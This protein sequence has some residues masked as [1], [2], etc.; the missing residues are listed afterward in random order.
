MKKWEKQARSTFSLS[1]RCSP[2]ANPFDAIRSSPSSIETASDM[3]HD[4]EFILKKVVKRDLS[5]RLKGLAELSEWIA[6]NSLADPLPS[7]ISKIYAKYVFDP[8]H[9]VRKALYH[10]LATIL[11]SHG[12]A[13]FAK[14]LRD[15][16]FGWIGS[17]DDPQKS[18]AKKALDA[19]SLLVPA[20]R[21]DDFVKLASASVFKEIEDLWK[22]KQPEI[23]DRAKAENYPKEDIEWIQ[24]LIC[25]YTLNALAFMYRNS[26]QGKQFVGKNLQTILELDRKDPN[27]RVALYRF[28]SLAIETAGVAPEIVNAAANE[29]SSIAGHAALAYI[30]AAL[31]HLDDFTCISAASKSV[32]KFS[33][34]TIPSFVELVQLLNSY[35]N[36]FARRFVSQFEEH[37]KATSFF[38][39]RMPAFIEALLKTKLVCGGSVDDLVESLLIERPAMM[40]SISLPDALDILVRNHVNID[41]YVPRLLKP[42]LCSDVLSF[43]SQRQLIDTALLLSVCDALSSIDDIL[44][45]VPHLPYS[46]A[47]NVR[48]E[49]IPAGFEFYQALF[50]WSKD[51]CYAWGQVKGRLADLHSFWS[52]VVANDMLPNF[53]REPMLWE[54]STTLD[55]SDPLYQSLFARSWNIDNGSI[56]PPPDIS[57]DLASLLVFKPTHRLS[58]E[59][60]E[61]FVIEKKLQYH[62]FVENAPKA[63]DFADAFRDRYSKAIMT[64]REQAMFCHFAAKVSLAWNDQSTLELLDAIYVAFDLSRTTY[65]FVSTFGGFYNVS[66]AVQATQADLLESLKIHVSLLKW[67][68]SSPDLLCICARLLCDLGIAKAGRCYPP[69]CCLRRAWTDLL[70]LSEKIDNGVLNGIYEERVD[71]QLVLKDGKPEDGLRFASFLLSNPSNSHALIEEILQTNRFGLCRLLSAINLCCSNRIKVF[72]LKTGTIAILLAKDPEMSIE[73]AKFIHCIAGRTDI[74]DEFW[75]SQPETFWQKFNAKQDR[76][77]VARLLNESVAFLYER[78]LP[79][80]SL[81]GQADLLWTDFLECPDASLCRLARAYAVNNSERIR[82][83]VIGHLWGAESRSVL[84]T[85]RFIFNVL[86]DR[87]LNAIRSRLAPG[88]YSYDVLFPFPK[89]RLTR[90]PNWLIFVDM[91][92]GMSEGSGEDIP[93]YNAIYSVFRDELSDVILS[94]L[95]S[96]LMDNAFD[97][98]GHEISMVDIESSDDQL[99]L[100]ANLYQ[101]ILR[102]FPTACRLCFSGLP[103]DAQRHVEEYTRTYFSTALIAREL[104]R[105][106]RQSASKSDTLSIRIEQSSTSLTLFAR[107][108]VE[109]LAM[110]IQLSVPPSFPLRP[111]LI[112]GGERLGLPEA[113]WRAWLLACQSVFSSQ[114]HILALIPTGRA[115]MEA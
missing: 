37:V 22:F 98:S 5:T 32:L 67:I 73:F 43:L 4:L 92:V 106:R 44:V 52:H 17:L 29:A 10:I 15:L 91:L 64:P 65:S 109:D 82:L 102:C 13:A 27:V 3:P 96:T 88:S 20:G 36:A 50:S 87:H 34:Q 99:L 86:M 45:V 25:V 93:I 6:A 83:S 26:E 112:E 38:D 60:A 97:P 84:L 94:R 11:K 1:L 30:R 53:D 21:T 7:Q 77:A 59:L 58:W 39:P 62:A 108:L 89:E 107:Y 113:K 24:S 8:E 90:S 111:V 74:S 115:L 49:H 33:K 72:S 75:I 9:R 57:G 28:A 101:R 81:K 114:V 2:F 51:H 48:F 47:T 61:G 56:E 55:H 18:T 105:L 63:D 76:Q 70:L 103:K 100:S 46:E 66:S 14:I 40:S 35:N 54:Y 42:P 69:T 12:K 110:Q 78:D 31:P 79:I 16:A 19:F 85:S 95:L 23:L 68:T 71:W 104:D 80:E 41:S